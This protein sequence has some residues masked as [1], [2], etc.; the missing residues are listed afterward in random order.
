MTPKI[1]GPYVYIGNF[2]EKLQYLKNQKI[3]YNSIKTGL[4]F[5]F[6]AFI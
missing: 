5:V 4:Y 3:F 1:C 2:L 6:K